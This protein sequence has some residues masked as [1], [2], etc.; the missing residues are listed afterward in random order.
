LQKPQGGSAHAS[1]PPRHL[2]GAASIRHLT[3]LSCGSSGSARQLQSITINAVSN[4]GEISF[5]ATGNY[6]LAPLT[7]TPLP[8]SW[9]VIDPSG[10]YTLTTQPFTTGCNWPHGTMVTV[11][12]AV[13]PNA[14][15]TGSDSG[16]KLIVATAPILCP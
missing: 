13:D 12:A 16:T 7:V 14:P 1:T 8:A 4:N 10:G 6:N 5:S 15:T 9:Y 2:F 3:T 11:M